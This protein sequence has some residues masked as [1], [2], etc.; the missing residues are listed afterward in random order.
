MHCSSYADV[1]GPTASDAV[2]EHALRPPVVPDVY[3]IVE[4]RRGSSMS[5]PSTPAS[6]SSYCV[7]ARELA[8][9][10]DEQRR[11]R[12]LGDAFGARHRRVD[13]QRLGA[14][15]LDD[16]VDLVGREVPVDGREPEAAARRGGDDFDELGAV[17]AQQRDAIA[18]GHTGVA[19]HAHERLALAFSSPKVR[20]PYSEYTATRSGSRAAACATLIPSSAAAA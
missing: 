12:R 9:D 6:R 18:V 14:A 3:S 10:A 16:V 4:P 5:E 7:A 15:V 11:G 2:A 19:Q 20:S 17:A 8:G 13:E 1:F